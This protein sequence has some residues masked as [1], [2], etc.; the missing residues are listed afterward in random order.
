MKAADYSRPFKNWHPA[1]TFPKDGK[2]VLARIKGTNRHTAAKWS[3]YNQGVFSPNYAQSIEV[4]QWIT[5]EEFADIRACAWRKY[6]TR[7]PTFN[8]KV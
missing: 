7:Q 4:E 3:E 5:F 6:E 1:T 2:L 8:S